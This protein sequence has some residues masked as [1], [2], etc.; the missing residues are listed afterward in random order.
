[1]TSVDEV[2]ALL[3]ANWQ[4]SYP[5]RTDVPKPRIIAEATDVKRH[6]M[7]D[8]DLLTVRDGGPQDFKPQGLA[9]TEEKV[10]ARLTID[11]RTVQSRQRL[12]GY[13][14]PNT[15][16][17]EPYSGLAGEVKRILDDNRKGFNNW[18]KVKADPFND[19]SGQ[20]GFN[21]WRGEYE[22]ELTQ[23]VNVINP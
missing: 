8:Q 4:K 9:W 1:M 11:L 20:M 17:P 10:T 22:V 2:A 21:H 15:G 7:K 19:L 16:L 5:D 23:Y 6:N 18:D 12:L 14:D 13:I 3:D